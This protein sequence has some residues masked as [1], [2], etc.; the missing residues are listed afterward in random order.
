[1]LSKRRKYVPKNANNKQIINVRVAEYVLV[2]M[3][4]SREYNRPVWNSP[5]DWLKC[6]KI[7]VFSR[8]RITR[9]HA[10]D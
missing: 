6:D 3:C 7:D 9:G 8:K 10:I 4:G 2:R 1:M 5:F